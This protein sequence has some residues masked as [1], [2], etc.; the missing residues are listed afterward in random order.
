MKRKP[1]TK[2]SIGESSVA[3]VVDYALRVAGD[4]QVVVGPLCW[5]PSDGAASKVWYFILSTCEKKRGWRCDQVCVPRGEDE[6]REFYRDRV[7]MELATRRP[8]IVHD[9]DDEVYMAR[10][11][12]A[13][14][15]GE[16]ISRIR[17]EIEADY[18]NRKNGTRG[19][20]SEIEAA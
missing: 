4:N 3:S 13:L 7:L 16:R 8:L 15:P 19:T 6:D 18:A 20:S 11:C 1:G 5:Q 12:E 2:Q 9:V 14:W 17:K 10:L